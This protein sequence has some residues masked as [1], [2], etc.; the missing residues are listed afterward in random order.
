VNFAVRVVAVWF[1]LNGF[2][3]VVDVS[4][5]T[6]FARGLEAITAMPDFCQRTV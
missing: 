3:Q 4:E 6:F 1:R 2:V 5:I